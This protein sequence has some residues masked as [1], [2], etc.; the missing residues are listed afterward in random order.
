VTVAHILGIPVEEGVLQLAPA[1]A[2]LV[3]AIAIGVRTTLDRMRCL[4]QPETRGVI[5]RLPRF[6]FGSRGLRAAVGSLA[7]VLAATLSWA[8]AAIADSSGSGAGTITGSFS[9]GC[10]DFFSRATKIGSSQGKDISYVELHY[11]DGR[12][13]KNET[14]TSPDYA[15][16]GGA[17]DEIDFA[18]VKSATTTERFQCERENSP[19]TAILEVKTPECY[20][21]LDGLV[22]CDGRTA[23][24]SW[25]HSTTGLGYGVIRFF[26]S[27]PDDQSCVDHVMPCELVELYSACR[28]TYTFRGTSST[29]LDDDILSW[30]LDFGDGT[31]LAGDWSTNPP[32]EISHEYLDRHCPTCSRQPATLTVTDSAGQTDTDAQF[33]VH[34][35]PE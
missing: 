8:G 25:S 33:V 15:I 18:I 28:V 9:D 34:T 5:R 1:G 32:T 2:A 3:T 35:Y 30:S 17:G 13:V 14:I 6:G 22:D 24:T 4:R 11:A 12:V 29:D 26:C 10:S 21:W 20:T 27:W 7:L 31:S 19:P 16:D 23:R